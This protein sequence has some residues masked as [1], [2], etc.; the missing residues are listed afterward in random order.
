MPN[1][2]LHICN[3]MGEGK[4]II[5]GKLLHM[6][7]CIP[8]MKRTEKRAKIS[9]IDAQTSEL[10]GFISSRIHD[11]EASASGSTKDSTHTE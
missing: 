5:R 9:Q 11:S 10:S 3:R 8:A 1:A 4:N 7:N 2:V 6:W